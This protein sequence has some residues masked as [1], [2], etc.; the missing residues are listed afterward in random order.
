LRIQRESLFKKYSQNPRE[1]QLAL[2]IRTVDD[3]IAEYTDRMRQQTR[4]AKFSK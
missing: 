1:L 3:Q 4:S 2:E